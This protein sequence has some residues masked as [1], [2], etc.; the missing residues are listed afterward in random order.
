MFAHQRSPH[1]VFTHLHLC[2]EAAEALSSA[3]SPAS[4]RAEASS[5]ATETWRI[6][7]GTFQRPLGPSA[8]PKPCSLGLSCKKPAP[9][10][11]QP[12][13]L[14]ELGPQTEEPQSPAS[15]WQTLE[16][17]SAHTRKQARRRTPKPGAA[18]GSTAA[19]AE[20]TRANR[21]RGLFPV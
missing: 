8:P 4:L 20:T 15:D 19:N 13:L 17:A 3:G 21:A 9:S 12:L 11:G 2:Q 16:A 6:T 7:G 5:K 14:Q 10:P 18:S 1:T